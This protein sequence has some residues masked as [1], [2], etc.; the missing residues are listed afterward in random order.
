MENKLS[1]GR[2]KWGVLVLILVGLTASSA[3]A[4]QSQGPPLPQSLLGLGLVVGDPE[5]WGISGKIWL[6]HDTALQPAL[7]L[8]W[9]GNLAFECDLLW[10]NYNVIPSDLDSWPV[11]IGL[12]GVVDSSGPSEGIRGILGL[13]YI[14][15]NLPGDFY[16]QLVPTYWL[17]GMA[18]MVQLYGE[19]G[20]RFYL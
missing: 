14:F 17:S 6:D 15:R 10:H 18:T 19:V 12:G 4:T 3:R 2:W 8:G 11:Y 13:D 16:V 9:M 20:F 1:S 7:K 5:G